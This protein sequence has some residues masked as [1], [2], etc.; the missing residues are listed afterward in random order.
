MRSVC[1]R[2]KVLCGTLQQVYSVYTPCPEEP[3]ILR[4]LLARSAVAAATLKQ[5]RPEKVMVDS[6]AV[7][8]CANATPSYFWDSTVRGGTAVQ[9]GQLPEARVSD[10]R[11]PM[12]PP[13]LPFAKFSLNAVRL[14]NP[15]VRPNSA[16]TK[17]PRGR[18]AHSWTGLRGFS[19][20]TEGTGD[21]CPS[22]GCDRRQRSKQA[23]R[24]TF[25]KTRHGEKGPK[26]RAVT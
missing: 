23:L 12:L 22:A 15:S 13:V 24:L 18:C 5:V 17:I 25:W 8:Q 26:T 3:G 6:G 1:S 16:S 21:S 7:P 19:Q 11:R 10:G 4:T 9:H 20:R 14:S 2:E